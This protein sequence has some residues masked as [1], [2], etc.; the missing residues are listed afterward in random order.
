MSIIRNYSG[1]VHYLPKFE[2]PE[3]L[4]KTSYTSQKLGLT[5]FKD[6]RLVKP[7]LHQTGQ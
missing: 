5:F 1:T 4:L 7:R 6:Y 3:I 2:K